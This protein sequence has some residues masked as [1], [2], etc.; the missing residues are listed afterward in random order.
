MSALSDLRVI[1]LSTGVSG[2]FFARLLADFGADVVKVEAPSGDSGRGL[3]PLASEGSGSGFFTYLNANKRGA[4][5]DLEA[6]DG[7]DKMLG[8]V[9]G[10]DVLV[11]SFV[12]GTL[13]R[14]GL[15]FDALAA[16]NPSLIVTSITPYGQTGTWAQRPGNN[17]TAFAGSGWA[18]ANR[19]GDRAPLMHH[20]HQTAFV[21]GQT[22]LLATLSA[23]VYRDR[24]GSGQHI[25]VSELEALT[26]IFS[27]R[28]LEV[29]HSDTVN[30][31]RGA[32]ADFFSGPV[33]CVDGYFA[34]TISRAHFWRDAMNVLG[35][36]DLAD[37]EQYW[38]RQ[39]NR[40]AL[41]AR[42]D[43]AIAQ[44]KKQ[45]LFDTLATLRVVGGMV[46]T[47]E[48]LYANEHVRDRGFFVE[49][50]QPGLGRI[51]LPGAPFK[52]SAS[53]WT[54]RRPAPALGEHTAELL[55]EAQQPPAGRIDLNSAPQTGLKPANPG[56]P[57]QDIRAIV[58]THAWGGAYCTELLGMLG[59]DVIQVE[60]RQRPDSW[61]GGSYSIPV[62]SKLRDLPQAQHGWNTNALYNA[63]NHSKRCV[64]LNLAHPEGVALYKR[65]VP[66]ADVVVENFSPRVM[67]NLGLS[68]DELKA[69]KPDIILVSMSAYGHSGPYTN[70]PGIG[71]T[72]EPMSGLSGL[73]GYEG[74][75]PLNSGLMYPDPV[76]GCYAAA[77]ALLAIRH[78]DRT[79]EGQHVDLSMQETS[80]T[81]IADA[82]VDFA[83]NGRVQERSGNRHETIAPHNMY[84]CRHGAW[85][86]IAAE[87]DDQWHS[88]CRIAGQEEWGT[89]ARFAT[90][91]TRKANEA[92]LDAL[93]EA[94]TRE[95]DAFELEELLG[96]AGI[97]AAVA[98]DGRQ[99]ATHPQHVD[100]GFIVTLEHPETGVLEYP[101]A[102]T[103]MSLTPPAVLKPA[104]LQGEHSWE[105]FRELLGMTEHEYER[106][107]ELGISGEGPP[108]E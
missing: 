18:D 76:A 53:P 48:E 7:R 3:P 38:S 12:P 41:V 106:L 34:L 16:V 21:A 74:D 99:V 13:E 58:V 6:A 15:G 104:S 31:P 46:L 24:H 64:T 44:W 8:L 39:N 63:V 83:L 79:G 84:P 43:P 80:M 11:E 36:P 17:L 100:R 98:R 55:A 108:P 62:P 97:A 1:D 89:D 5:L 96:A 28:F 42:V 56:G 86:A 88:L 23:L 45:E 52:M 50:D 32:T 81:F 66:F 27:P 102:P 87:T 82:L 60:S 54:L 57:L 95:Q 49:I 78:R 26:E 30:R 77:A 68:Y 94:W 59:A 51:E 107:V 90:N 29:Q 93:I 40:D 14:L 9:R 2:P 19:I 65:L 92:A 105:V 91:E 20:G 71:G 70:V 37:A 103:R 4:V 22:A 101:G 10:A 35:L 47:T 69:I 67:G 85:I 33:P 61:R 25:D 72:I 75:R 73:L